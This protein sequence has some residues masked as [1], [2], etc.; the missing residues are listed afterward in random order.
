MADSDIM[1]VAATLASG[2]LVA[3]TAKPA[4][5]TKATPEQFA[6]MVYFDCLEAIRAERS[7]RHQEKSPAVA[8]DGA[9]RT[10]LD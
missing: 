4:S 7:K 10:P 1:V 9:R 8:S 6:A 5:G 2:L 3:G